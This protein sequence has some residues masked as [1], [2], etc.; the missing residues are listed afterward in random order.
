[1]ALQSTWAH[2]ERAYGEAS[3]K[4][5]FAS[6]LATLS[7]LLTFGAIYRLYLHPLAHVPG[8]FIA[9]L[10]GLW[11]DAGYRRGKWHEDVLAIHEKYGR[12]VRIAPNEVSVV[13][14]WAMKNLYGHGHNAVK[15]SWYAVWDPPQT[16]PQLFSAL[17]KKVHGFLRKRVSG[18]YSMSSILKYEK[19]I[20]QCLDL[21][22]S[23]LHDYAHQGPIDMSNWTNAFAF[24][25]VGELGYG[26]ELGM[27]KTETDVNN[28]RRDIFDVFKFLSCMG[29]FPGQLWIMSN[30]VSATIINLLGAAPPLAPFRDWTFKQV[31]E[32]LDY[33]DEVKREDMLQHFCRMKRAD[34]SPVRAEEVV[35]EAMNLM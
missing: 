22:L 14:E 6:V 29:H 19:Y 15:T 20:Q 16:A 11:R 34:G 7:I 27:L 3:A 21:L 25:V 12:V 10:S 2:L 13:D 23:K 17:D 33:I 31:Q 26:S 18:A 24:D 4:E 32:R 1:M 8:P 9:K 5:I 28:L 35:I 30:A